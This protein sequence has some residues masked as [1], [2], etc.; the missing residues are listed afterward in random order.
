MAFKVTERTQE[1]TTSTGAAG[2][3]LGGAPDTMFTF[4]QAGF[5]NG[6]TFLGCIEHTTPGIN[7]VE[8]AICTYNS[9]AITR[10]TPKKS[11]AALNATVNFSAG[12]KLITL[13]PGLVP[14]Q[15]IGAPAISAGALS[16][17]VSSY[18][19]F[20][21]ANNANCTVTFDNAQPGYATSFTLQLTADGTLRTWTWPGSVT[22]LGGSAPVLSSVNGKRDLMTFLSHDA[23]TT[24]LGQVIA[25]NY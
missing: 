5:V 13:I 2:L 15:P 10:A 1:I 23:G 14:L 24:W 20:N 21:V 22:W 9:G 17:D 19:L 7:E 6:D 8:I 18:A 16:L 25:Q 3:T 12:T 4:A 11:S